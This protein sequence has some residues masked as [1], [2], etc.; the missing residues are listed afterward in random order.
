MLKTS[1]SLIILILTYKTDP[2]LQMQYI[3][4]LKFGQKKHMPCTLSFRK[5]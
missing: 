4:T 2:V 1:S 3:V 5:L